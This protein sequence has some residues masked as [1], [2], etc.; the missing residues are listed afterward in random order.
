MTCQNR[1]YLELKKIKLDEYGDKEFVYEFSQ[2]GYS[3]VLSDHINEAIEI[4]KLNTEAFP[5]SSK[6]FDDLGEACMIKGDKELAIKYYSRAY[7][8]DKGNV[9]VKN[10]L[11]KLKSE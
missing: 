4:Y 9:R 8:L 1:K 7:D 6:A 5:L 10:I 3:L 11:D 2:L